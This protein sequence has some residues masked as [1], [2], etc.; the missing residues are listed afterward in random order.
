MDTSLYSPKF[1]MTVFPDSCPGVGPVA[2]GA[3]PKD[4]GEDREGCLQCW[5]PRDAAP[6]VLYHADTLGKDSG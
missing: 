4:M 3:V 5:A 2:P 1:T 6:G